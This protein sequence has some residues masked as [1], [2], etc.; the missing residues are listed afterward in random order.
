MS[1]STARSLS[2]LMLFVLV[3]SNV[4]GQQFSPAWTLK[5][6]YGGGTPIDA[7]PLGHCTATFSSDGAVRI[8]SKGRRGVEGP[9][10][11]VVYET[12]KL[13]PE[14]L[15]AIFNAADAALREK[16]FRRRGANEDGDFVLE[17]T[18]WYPAKVS[19]NEMN[20]FADAP[21]AMQRLLEL[22]TELLP[23]RERIARKVRHPKSGSR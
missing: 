10:D 6:H 16:P 22:I 9:A 11:M 18:G 21:P 5:L 3:A 2:C 4:Q 7:G 12:N 23:E 15:Q 8:E 19:H 17:R 13:D 14:R 20:S 1:P